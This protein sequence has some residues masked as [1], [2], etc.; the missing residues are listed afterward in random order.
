MTTPSAT[1]L[2]YTML[3]KQNRIKNNKQKVKLVVSTLGG[4]KA[5]GKILFPNVG[6]K[7]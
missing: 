7:T 4:T 5:P 2:I 1:Q 3:I 6:L